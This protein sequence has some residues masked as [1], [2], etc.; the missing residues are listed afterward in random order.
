[1]GCEQ[2]LLVFLA[3]IAHALVFHA[4]VGVVGACQDAVRSISQVK[5]HIF[6]IT[7]LKIGTVALGI[8]DAEVGFYAEGFGP[9]VEQFLE[10]INRL[11]AFQG[12]AHELSLT[13]HVLHAIVA[14]QVVRSSIHNGESSLVKAHPCGRVLQVTRVEQ[15]DKLHQS[16]MGLDALHA[17]IQVVGIAVFPHQG[18]AIGRQFSAHDGRRAG[19][20]R[21]QRGC[22]RQDG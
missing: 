16:V 15:G 2:R 4:A 1:M 19:V 22:H 3:H 12:V 9:G 18:P 21:D 6:I 17:V 11:A 8:D 13:V 5:L 10:I 14:V 20:N 7:C